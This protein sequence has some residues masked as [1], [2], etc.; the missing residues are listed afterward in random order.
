MPNLPGPLPEALRKAP[1]TVAQA[2]ALGLT[3]NDLA[4]PRVR[5]PLHGV[6][7]PAELP[8]D[9]VSRCLAAALLLPADAVFD[10]ATALALRQI[11]LP[12]EVAPGL[13]IVA[14][15][16]R[17]GRRPQVRGLRVHQLPA[18]YPEPIRRA[19]LKLAPLP[20][21][22]A[23]LAGLPQV[24]VDD[25]VVAGDAVISAMG[26]N[27]LSHSVPRSSRTARATKL[28]AALD[29]VR[30][31]SQSPRETRTRL[32][33]LRAGLPE[34][35]LNQHVLDAGGQWVATP[36]L[37]WPGAK[38]IVEYDGEQHRTDAT[39]YYNDITRRR[40]LEDAGWRVL[41]VTSPDLRDP[42]RLAEKV[43]FA[44]RQR[45]LNW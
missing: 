41:I 20:A 24:T 16:P 27:V 10:G 5:R 44:L 34:P 18:P 36:D 4:G 15:V 45:G 28:R 14:A 22:W 2:L 43:A 32:I 31:G 42:H 30:V 25:L 3:D 21:A 17:G 9:L 40:L 12:A 33:L 1:F 6:R 37:R 11:L 8:D 39:R 13:P 23:R 29:L 35:E 26:G 7:V 38:L 19:G